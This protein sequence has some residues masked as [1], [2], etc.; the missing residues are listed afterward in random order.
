MTT[1]RFAALAA[2]LACAAP[3][4]ADES[5]L[6]EF[7]VMSLETAQLAAGETLAACRKMGFQVSVSVVDRFGN[8][9]V[10]LRDRFAGA[11]TPDTSRRKAWTAVSFRAA[12]IELA[13]LTQAGQPQSAAR[14]ITGAL[15]LGGGITV[16]AAGSIVGGIGVSGA[17]TGEDDQACAE[18]GAEAIR[19]RIEL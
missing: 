18:A 14:D 12:T 13:E 10:L 2:A 1:A 7:K 19:A 4:A 3:A 5:A 11:H 8:L 16:E 6:V 15:M 9:Q 17:P